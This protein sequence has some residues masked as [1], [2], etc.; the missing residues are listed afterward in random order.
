M[1]QQDIRTKLVHA[2]ERRGL[3]EAQPVATPIY[4]S[5]TFTYDSMA[6]IDRVFSGEKQGFIYTRYGN[7]TTAALE[8]AVRAV[9]EGAIACAYATGMAA[10]HAALLACDLK[11]G[12][13]VLASQDVYG[14]TTNLL[15]TILINFGVKTVHVDFSDLETVRAK[16]REL[17]PQVLIAETISNPLLKV[18]DIE[19][20]VQ[21][22][23]ENGARLIV[24]N[25]FASP[26]LRQPLKLGADLV[27]HSATKYLSGHADAM[28]GLVV[29][30]DEMDAPALFSV[31]KLVGG[32]LGVWDAHEILRGLKTLALRMERQCENA[33]R[34]ASYLK[35]HKGIGRVHYPG[36]GA[37]V[38]IE[39]SDDTQDAAFRFM[40]ALKMCVRSTSLGD[41]F[42]SVLHPATASHRDFLP[43]RRQELG[44]VDGLVRISV[45][46]ESIDDIIADIE[47]ALL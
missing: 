16:A 42:T 44:I 15:N 27:V 17:R 11:S 2:G 34:L 24:D 5:A 29:S 41:V 19:T 37:L 12:S 35:E 14:A 9:E 3:P 23:H 40:D 13:T 10:V 18:C 45:G 38:S 31:M 21:I 39:L 46:I 22:A 20:C 32:V 4:A 33:S 26:Y 43:A 36:L 6:E 8:E 7:P 30:R 28:G 47:Q 1:T 25:T